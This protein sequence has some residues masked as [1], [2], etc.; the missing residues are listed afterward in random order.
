MSVRFRIESLWRKNMEYTKESLQKQKSA[1]KLFNFRP[2]LFCAISLCFGIVFSYLQIHEGASAWWLMLWLPLGALPFCFCSTKKK[3][4]GVAFTVIALFVS[5]FIGYNAFSAQLQDFTA[6]GRYDGIYTAQGRV[7]DAT[8]YEDV[9]KICLDDVKIGNKEETGKLIAYLSA[10]FSETVTLSDVILLEGYVKTNTDFF[11][12]YGF[13]AERIAEDQRYVMYDAES[14]EIVENR[15]DLFLF[16]RARMQKVVQEG[17]QGDVSAV[18]LGVLTGN[19]SGMDEGL[20][21]NIRFGGIAHI[22]AVSGMHVG[23]LYG[24]CTMLLKKSAL[25]KLP[26]IAQGL[27]LAVLLFFYAGICGFSASI[28]RATTICLV[29]YTAKAL[30]LRS[31]LLQSLG[32]A[33]IIVLLLSPVSLFCVGFQLSFVSCLG[34]ALLARPF[35]NGLENLADK[36]VMAFRKNR[37]LPNPEKRRDKSLRPLTI[38]ERIARSCISFLSVSLSA[39]VATAPI[40]L[41]SFGYLSGWALLLNFLFVPLLGVVFSWLLM[42]VIVG[43]FLPVSVAAVVLYLPDLFWSLTLLL[44]ETV[45]FSSFAVTQLSLSGGGIL[46]YYGAC[47]FLTDKWNI[48]IK[49]KICLF[50]VC[51]IGFLTSVLVINL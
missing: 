7:V 21:E 16:L 13:V 23:A 36:I 37:A 47:L 32:F 14:C 45:D 33:G 49:Q 43:C 5:F 19:V 28:L 34:I 20:L 4:K 12:Q 29:S 26:K 1:D 40:L 2:M 8:L 9:V 41:S 17:M 25:K 6:C 30:G 50:S 22:F 10:S 38:G 48:T 39:Q 24:F 42:F 51:A 11:D 35:Q 31:D 46:C 3:A 15:F 44:F 27:L 18:M